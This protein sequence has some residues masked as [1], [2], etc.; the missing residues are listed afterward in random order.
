MRAKADRISLVGKEL[1][2]AGKRL[3]NKQQSEFEAAVSAYL[4]GEE[5]LGVDLSASRLGLVREDGLHSAL[6]GAEESRVLLALAS[7]QE[8]GSTPS[9]LIPQDRGWDPATLTRVMQ[10]LS[11]STAQIIIMSTVEPEPVEGWSLV[12]VEG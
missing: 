9:V 6:S 3:L 12:H 1:A 8:D 7:A 4:P 11:Q 5:T 10:A 2:K